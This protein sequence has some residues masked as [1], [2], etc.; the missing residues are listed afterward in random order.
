MLFELPGVN[1]VPDS[2]AQI[3]KRRIHSMAY[4]TVE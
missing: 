3:H 4:L 1:R 2:S